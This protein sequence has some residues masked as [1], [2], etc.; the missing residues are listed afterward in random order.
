MMPDLVYAGIAG[1]G[2]SS[3]NLENEVFLNK[4]D[5]KLMLEM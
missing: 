4:E 2:V 1:D 3:F 5:E